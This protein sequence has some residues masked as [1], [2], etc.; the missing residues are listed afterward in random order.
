[1]SETEK[2]KILEGNAIL[3]SSEYKNFWWSNVD[4]E[5]CKLQFA[6]AFEIEQKTWGDG[7]QDCVYQVR[8]KIFK[9][10]SFVKGEQLKIFSQ[11]QYDGY[12][13]EL[14]KYRDDGKNFL[15][16]CEDVPTFD[17][18]DREWD[19]SKDTAIYFDE[20]ITAI[21][22]KYGYKIP[23]IKIYFDL[24]AADAKFFKWL[25]YIGFNKK[26][27]PEVLDRGGD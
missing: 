8:E 21:E 7:L 18:G 23:R 13:L 3:N 26:N 6:Q 24:K 11:R 4:K 17:S 19:S 10:L 9:D 20:V 16:Q 5:S 27:F 1:M 12:R 25:F 15:Y 14:R 22:C 2:I